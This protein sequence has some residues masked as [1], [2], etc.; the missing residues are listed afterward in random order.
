VRTI[1]EECLSRVVPLG[2]KHLRHCITE[3]VRHYHGE[4]PHQGLDNELIDPEE[5]HGGA[6]GAVACRQRLG[7]MLNYY[8]REAA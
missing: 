2:E 3:F 1:K 5:A 4:R 7:G 8:Y 6:V